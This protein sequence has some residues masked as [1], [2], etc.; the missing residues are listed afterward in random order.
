MLQVIPKTNEKSTICKTACSNYQNKIYLLFSV[1][2][3]KIIILI[4]YFPIF[5]ANCLNRRYQT[6][7]DTSSPLASLHVKVS[8][9]ESPLFTI[10]AID[11]SS[12]IA[13]TSVLK[14]I[15]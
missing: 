1:C 15:T 6:W 14:D 2:F 3:L 4:C 10:S 9:K 5:Q 13:L 8:S 12:R 7:L 11:T